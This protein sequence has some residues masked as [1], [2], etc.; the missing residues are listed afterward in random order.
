MARRWPITD[1]NPQPHG[2]R[3]HITDINPQPHGSR[4]G[5]MRLMVSHTQ[6]GL[7]APHVPHTHTGRQVYTLRYTQGGMVHSEVHTGRHIPT[8]VTLSGRHIPTVVTLSGRLVHPVCTPREAST[9]LYVHPERLYPRYTP[10]R[11]YP[12][13]HIPLL[14]TREAIP[15]AYTH[16]YT[17]EAIPREVHLHIHQGGYTQGGISPY[18]H[19]G[20]YTRG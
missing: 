13:R 12:G 6:G 2:S 11:L 5:S 8:V 7:Y 17:R 19:Q 20:G 15:R 3:E 4:E 16:L 14:Y 1:I 10:G 18:I 9:L